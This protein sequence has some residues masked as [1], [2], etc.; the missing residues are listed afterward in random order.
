MTDEYLKKMICEIIRNYLKVKKHFDE[1]KDSETYLEEIWSDGYIEEHYLFALNLMIE[2][3][4]NLNEMT[5]GIS[6]IN[7]ISQGGQS[8]SFNSNSNI[9]LTEEIKILLPTPVNVFSW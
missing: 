8:V 7:S 5:N 2:N 9:F 6:N 1:N 3:Y 4:K